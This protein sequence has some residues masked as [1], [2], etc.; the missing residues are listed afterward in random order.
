MYI[1]PFFL[2]GNPNQF[3]A[4]S[5]PKS[6]AQEVLPCRILCSDL[7]AGWVLLALA[8]LSLIPGAA[9]ANTP[10]PQFVTVAGSLQSE[11]GCP[12]DWMPDCAATHLAF[13]PVDD[14][15]QGT[16]DVPAGGYQYKAAL[17]NSWTENY[18]DHAQNNGGNI[19][20]NLGAAASVK[21]YYSHETHWI[22]SNRNAVI[23]TAPGSFQHFLGCAGDWQPDCLRSWLQDPDGDGIYSF[24]TRSIPA[25]SYETKVAINES[26]DENYGAGGAS[27]GANIPFTV[28]S[29]CAETVFSYNAATHV[30]TIARRLRRRPG[31][32]GERHHRRQPPVRARLPRRL[33]ARLRQ[34]PSDLRL[35]RRRLAGDLQHPGRQLRVQGARSTTR[36]TSTTAPT[37]SRGAPTSASPSPRRRRSSSITMTRRTG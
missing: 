14:V 1:L 13:D 5:C 9:L 36:G 23:A 2:A 29:D 35:H 34:H 21:F 3:R 31:P 19:S 4:R 33:A 20:L 17:N 12:N 28:A 26:W 27:N 30:L 25:G 22:T 18:G 8:L 10:T 7:R 6:Q 37:R 24:T 15:W 11:L 32:A 16:F